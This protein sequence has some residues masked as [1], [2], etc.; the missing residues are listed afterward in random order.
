MDKSNTVIA[1]NLF[2]LWKIKTCLFGSYRFT[3]RQRCGCCVGK[4]LYNS[5]YSCGQY[6]LKERRDKEKTW[7]FSWWSVEHGWFR[8]NI[9]ST[10]KATWM[11]LL[12]WNAFPHYFW[13]LLMQLRQN[14]NLKLPA[15]CH[16]LFHEK[17][18]MEQLPGIGPYSGNFLPTKSTC[19]GH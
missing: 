11:C 9:V 2:I 16:S 12:D 3:Q 8:K 19:R 6:L 7:N 10:F 15:E 14:K 5:F 1:E 18:K 13:S 17:P 4:L